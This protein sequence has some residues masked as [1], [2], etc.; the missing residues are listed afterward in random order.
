MRSTKVQHFQ[1]RIKVN[2]ARQ[3]EGN[4]IDPIC[5]IRC[6]NLF[7]N[8]KKKLAKYF[9]EKK[10]LLILFYLFFSFLYISK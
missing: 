10:K 5:E 7:R 3:L 4:N 8:T 6:S 2:E 1:I 9:I